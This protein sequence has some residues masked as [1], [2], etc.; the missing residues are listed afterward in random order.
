MP[1]EAPVG[2]E[3]PEV[4]RSRPRRDDVLPD[5]VPRA[6]VREGEVVDLG[7]EGETAQVAL[8]LLAELP[9][10]PVDRGGR[11][12]VEGLC[13]QF[14]NGGQIVVAGDCDAVVPAE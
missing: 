6:A 10:G 2:P 12:V 14:A 11:V 4:R 7:L 13:A 1:D 5:R 3:V 9:G 8:L